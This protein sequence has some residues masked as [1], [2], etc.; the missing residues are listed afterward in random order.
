[1]V[2]GGSS[3]LLGEDQH[4]EEIA[5]AAAAAAA[6][7]VAAARPAP[8]QQLDFGIVATAATISAREAVGGRDKRW[9]KSWEHGVVSGAGWGWRVCVH[10]FRF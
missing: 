7:V 9:E 10:K 2:V 1:L 8:I 5:K 4:Q 3:P 6:V